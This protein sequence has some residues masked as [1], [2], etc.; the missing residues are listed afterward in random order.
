MLTGSDGYEYAD[1]T[2]RLLGQPLE[3]EYNAQIKELREI[4]YSE[5]GIEIYIAAYN[6]TCGSDHYRHNAGWRAIS[7][8]WPSS[9]TRKPN[10]FSPPS[11]TLHPAN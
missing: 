10:P 11:F 6:A 1:I 2:Q 9:R 3:N 4:G 7:N 8:R 5:K